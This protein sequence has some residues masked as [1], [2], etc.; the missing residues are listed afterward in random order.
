MLK[1]VGLL[2]P[3]HTYKTLSTKYGPIQSLNTQ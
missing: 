2:C 3:A 1:K